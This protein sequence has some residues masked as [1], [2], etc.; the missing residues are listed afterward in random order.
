MSNSYSFWEMLRKYEFLKQRKD[1][2]TFSLTRKKSL[3][4]I[5][6]TVEELKDIEK[7]IKKFERMKFKT[8]AIL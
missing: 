4:S 6:K 5:T 3:E 7:E 2:I 8:E 1:E